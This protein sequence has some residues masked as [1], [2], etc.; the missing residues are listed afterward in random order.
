MFRALHHFSLILTIQHAIINHKIG[1][2]FVNSNRGQRIGVQ[3][4]ILPYRFYRFS[5]MHMSQSNT[6]SKRIGDMYNM[7]KINNTATFFS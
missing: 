6:V 4:Y 3:K 1:I 5:Q 7:D 2:L